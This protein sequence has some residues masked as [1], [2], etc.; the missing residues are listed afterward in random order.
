MSLNNLKR[1][2]LPMSGP[3]G[4]GG[5]SGGGGGTTTT[6]SKTE[7]P[8]Y[9]QPWSEELMARAGAL[10]DTPYQSYGG[11]RIAD[12]PWDIQA[13]IGK[14]EQRA[15]AGSPLVQQ[16]QSFLQ[17][18][19]AGGQAPST[20]YNPY[21]GSQ[22]NVGSNDYFGE[23]PYLE[24]AIKRSLGDVQSRVSSQFGGSNYGT[25]ANQEVLARS[26]GDV[27]NTMR[28]QDYSQQQQLAEADINR[29]MVAQQGDLARNAQLGEA[30]ANRQ[31]EGYNADMTN[32]MRAAMFTPQMAQQDYQDAQAL[33]G[34]G[35]IRRSLQQEYLNSAYEDWMNQQ[36]WPYQ[37]M[38]VLANA[39]RTSMGGGG[40]NVTS[41]PNAYQSNRTANMI[42][43]GLLGYM[44]G[45][46]MDSPYIGAAGGALLGGLL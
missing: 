40:S 7:P 12:V 22:T 27:S 35:D 3:M 5:D 45:S 41:S 13:G 26:L 2:L 25:T 4:G 11:Q 8:A 16:G 43:G 36:Q 9:V 15:A 33:L 38:D 31:L 37:Q 6:I 39:I 24:N 23:N 10:S 46:Q 44:G 1:K 19:M 32:R 21:M 34:A 14:I 17:R 18:T 28:M 29:R 30:F 42:G 20:Y